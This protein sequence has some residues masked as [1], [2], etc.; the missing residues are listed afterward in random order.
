MLTNITESWQNNRKKI[1]LFHAK[2]VF[3]RKKRTKNYCKK[4]YGKIKLKN[5]EDKNNENQK[6]CSKNQLFS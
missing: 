6:I 5:S 3:Q 2:L 1:N 4:N